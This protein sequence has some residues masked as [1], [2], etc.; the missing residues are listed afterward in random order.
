[1]FQ[2]A[3]LP[4][5]TVKD[6]GTVVMMYETYGDDGKVPVHIASSD[7]FGASISSDI[8]ECGFTPLTL[9]QAT[10]TMMVFLLLVFRLLQ[11][12]VQTVNS[13][14]AIILHPLAIRFSE[15][16]QDWATSTREGS[17]RRV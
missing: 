5:L 9:A 1:M 4:A 13:A 14:I 7:D 6:D 15:F 17:I 11:M 12:V 3:A 2:R 8:E 10:R 16:L